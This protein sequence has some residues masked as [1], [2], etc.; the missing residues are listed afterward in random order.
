MLQWKMSKITT[1]KVMLGTEKGLRVSS[2]NV[3][4]VTRFRPSL[5]RHA[6]QRFHDF[7]VADGPLERKLLR[8]NGFA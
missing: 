1:E 5:V 2:K 7:C 6:G 4:Q 8:K 3:G